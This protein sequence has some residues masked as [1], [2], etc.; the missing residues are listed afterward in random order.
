MFNALVNDLGDYRDRISSESL[1]RFGL[2]NFSVSNGT[3]DNADRCVSAILHALETGGSAAVARWA[4]DMRDAEPMQI[5]ELAHAACMSIAAEV[6]HN[7]RSSFRDVMA[8]L[9]AVESDVA[10][11]LREPMK[12][13]ALAA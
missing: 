7:S 10:R 5:R 6:A 8:R 13:A 3:H 4:H 2:A 11:A 12:P 1:V 9:Q